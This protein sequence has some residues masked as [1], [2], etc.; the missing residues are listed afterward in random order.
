M[1][2]TIR[3]TFLFWMAALLLLS[4]P[5]PGSAAEGASIPDGEYSNLSY[6]YL[7]DGTTDTSA[8]NGFLNVADSGRLV[9]ENGQATFYHQITSDNYELLQYIAYRKPGAP[10]AT[11][12][13]NVVTGM[14]GYE[15]Y[16]VS[17]P[18]EDGGPV[19]V[20]IGMADPSE[21]IDVLMHVVI[22]DNP[23]YP[24]LN[25]D[26][27]YNVQLSVD[28]SALPT[29]S[30]GGEDGTSGNSGGT[31]SSGG[32]TG[33]Q[34]GTSGNS[35]GTG[36]SGGDTGSQDG[37]SGNSGGTGSS[38]GDA[39]S[40][41]GT[42]GNSGS[43][44]SSGGDAGSQ[45][46]TS[47]NSGGT[48]SSDPAGNP[49]AGS[50]ADGKYQ[51]DFQILKFGTSQAS[52]MD[53]YVAHPGRLL[54]QNGQKYVYILLRQSK[55]ITAFSVGGAPTQVT[56]SDASANTRWVRFPVADLTVVL[57]GH[58][59]IDW[60]E[61]NYFHEYDVQI[62]LGAYSAV[63]QWSGESFGTITERPNPGT[64][65]G[66]AE[67]D[68]GTQ[69]GASGS[70]GGTDAL[71]GTDASG[72]TGGAG[73]QQSGA[74]VEFSDTAGH[75]AA[76]DIRRAAERGIVIGFAD[77]TFRPNAAI[78]RVEFVT[79]LSRAFQLGGGGEELGF[80][81]A[82]LIKPWAQDAVKQAVA[83]GIVTGF[84]DGTFRPQLQIG[85][86]EAA[87]FVVRALGLPT[88][89]SADLT[90][91]DAA[92]IPAYARPYVAT[93][94]KYGLISGIDGNRFGAA[95]AFTRAQ[96]AALI[97]RAIDYAEAHA[98]AA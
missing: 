49:A 50:L 40:Q 41:D 61:M 17:S 19:E 1:N 38:G 87:V 42:S 46:G 66:S 93:S 44:G 71:S 18:S 78:S 26:N 72:E 6:V 82:D 34:D 2:M 36:S 63:A 59:K 51:I 52:V 79:M 58:V 37:S 31:G 53:E 98:S 47:G 85:R 77:G 10:K 8:A 39:G 22:K 69:D 84:A 65:G 11:V 23:A 16:R 30:G 80:A 13:D 9:V 7:K 91:A 62:K 95:V 92:Q 32:D 89:A 33:S 83:A 90:F 86:T 3:K 48:G 57:S 64:S 60:P 70:S 21:K 55:E 75:W 76:G 45:D 73:G 68:T 29:G 28:T 25:Y 54:V 88:E 20:A 4:F 15:P 67:A 94:V 35:G 27:W 81:D 12:V 96:A 24:G 43:T 74:S 97:V 14:D 5:S 56:E